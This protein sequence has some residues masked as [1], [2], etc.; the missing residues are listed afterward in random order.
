MT[1]SPGRFHAVLGALVL[2]VVLAAAP[3]RAQSGTPAANPAYAAAFADARA[4]ATSDVERDILA[5]DVITAT[6][7]R[8]ATRQFVTCLQDRAAGTDLTMDDDPLIPGA[9]VYRGSVA[10]NLPPEVRARVIE[11]CATGTTAIV[12]PLVIATIVNPANADLDALTLACLHDRAPGNAS[13][14][15]QDLPALRTAASSALARINPSRS[16]TT[17]DDATVS[18]LANPAQT[19]IETTPAATPRT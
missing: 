9:V 5:D 16:S 3:A 10:P 12:E 4:Q 1:R 17:P 14:T 8:E 6:E 18:C 7:Y 2:L 19:G 11:D 13:I 15:A